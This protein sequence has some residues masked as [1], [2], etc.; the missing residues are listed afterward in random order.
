MA[1]VSVELAGPGTCTHCCVGEGKL[2][3]VECNGRAV[4]DDGRRCGRVASSSSVKSLRI[5]GRWCGF[6]F[7]AGPR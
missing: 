4:A 3:C 5:S 2:V 1:I 7:T 6:A